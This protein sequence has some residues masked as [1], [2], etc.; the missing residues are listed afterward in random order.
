MEVMINLTYAV[1]RKACGEAAK[2]SLQNNIYKHAMCAIFSSV[3]KRTGG[4]GMDLQNVFSRLEGRLGERQQRLL[5]AAMAM[6]L[7]RGGISKAARMS[8]LSRPTIYNGIDELKGGKPDVALERQRRPGGGRKPAEASDDALSCELEKLIEPYT[9]G[10]PETPLRWTRKS[11]RTLS[12]ELRAAGHPASPKL[13]MRLLK[14][15]GYTLQSNRKSKEGAADPGRNAQFEFISSQTKSFQGQGLPVISVDAKKKELVGEFK[16]GGREWRPKGRSE[17][18]NV[19]DFIDRNLGRATPYGVYDLS[20]NEGWVNV[21]TDHDTAAFA[22]ETIRKWWHLMGKERYP[23]ADALF[24][25]ADGGGSNGSRSRLWKSELQ[26]LAEETGLRIH[27]S[28]FPPGTSKWN[29]IEHRMFSFISMNWRGRPLVSH[30]VILSLI[31]STTTRKGLKIRSGLDTRKYPPGLKV[32][33]ERF[34]AIRIAR[35]KFH[36]EWNYVISPSKL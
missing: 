3:T 10:D 23:A 5:A 7:G 34:N 16:N 35:D 21:G 2:G 13:V 29:K 20:N 12:S 1:E 11:L 22:V 31:A 4:E 14:A 33:D 36:G 18:V 19:Y 9:Q 25:T 15:L 26:G 32:E 6:E 27:V 30:E 28:H 8:G 17:E 24:I